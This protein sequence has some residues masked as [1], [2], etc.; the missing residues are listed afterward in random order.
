V[1]GHLMT[2][3]KVVDFGVED[4]PLE[5]VMRTLFKEHRA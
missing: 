2:T 1:V 5:D 4:P 3:L